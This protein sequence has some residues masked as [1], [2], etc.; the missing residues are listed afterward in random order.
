MEKLNDLIKSRLKYKVKSMMEE[1]DF[2]I[3][4]NEIRE[5]LSRSIL[6]TAVNQ[7]DE[8]EE[9][10]LISNALTLLERKLQEFANDAFKENE[11]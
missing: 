4:F 3:I 1:G 2:S 10:Y 5:D 11:Q 7:K 8:R 9:L 6:Q